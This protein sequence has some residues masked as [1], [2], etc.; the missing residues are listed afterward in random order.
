MLKYVGNKSYEKRTVSTKHQLVRLSY[1]LVLD[2]SDVSYNVKPRLHRSNVEPPF[3]AVRVS[4]KSR[5]LLFTRR[6]NVSSVGTTNVSTSYCSFQISWKV[7]QHE[8]TK[9]VTRCW[10]MKNFILFG[11]Q[12]IVRK[13]RILTFSTNFFHRRIATLPVVP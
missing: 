12:S 13:Y 11:V 3:A 1:Y 7:R 5:C 6:R 4:W 10:T 8:A 9:S 2:R